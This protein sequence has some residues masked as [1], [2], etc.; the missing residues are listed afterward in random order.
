[1]CPRYCSAD[2]EDAAETLMGHIQ[3]CVRIRRGREEEQGLR[4]ESLR[5]CRGNVDVESRDIR[6]VIESSD[7]LISVWSEGYFNYFAGR[8][9][10]RHMDR[11]FDQM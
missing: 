1:M 9:A 8:G 10:D 2:A 4:T 6:G 5:I 3:K 11:H 7:I